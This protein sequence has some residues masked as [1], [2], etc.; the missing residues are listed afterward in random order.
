MQTSCPA[1]GFAFDNRRTLSVEGLRG[2][3]LYGPER[4]I[5]NTKLTAASLDKCPSCGREF[6]S[7]PFRIP[8][9]FVRVKIRSMGVVYA[10]VLLVAVAVVV[11]AA[12]ARGS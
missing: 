7:A 10:L 3:F 11:M 2:R 8:G 6:V 1:C 12:F 4:L 5:V 9:E